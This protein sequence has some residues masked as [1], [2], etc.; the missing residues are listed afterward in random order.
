[1][2]QK[3]VILILAAVAVVIFA[4]IDFLFILVINN[5]IAYDKREKKRNNG[6]CYI[7]IQH[8]SSPMKK[9]VEDF[10]EIYDFLTSS[11]DKYY[12]IYA[13][14]VKME[15][16]EFFDYGGSGLVETKNGQSAKK[17]DAKTLQVSQNVLED[18]HIETEEGRSLAGEDFNYFPE[19]KIPV[20]M[21]SAYRDIYQIGDT[22]WAKYLFDIYEFEIVGIIQEGAE[23]YLGNGT[24]RLDEYIIMPSFYI[25]GHTEVT[26]GI[27]IH[28]ANKTSGILKVPAEE[29]ER[30]EN[31]YR[32]M[33]E[34]NRAGEYS[35][36]ISPASV[37]YKS[38]M[39]VDIYLLRN[40]AVLMLMALVMGEIVVLK[41]VKKK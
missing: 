36:T 12:E 27:K 3:K 37:F 25:S 14:P 10:Q 32:P 15:K 35:W 8:E 9:E 28:Y 21:G 16:G 13:Q 20:L 40:I 1:M 7:S 26:D 4:V 17:T 11:G 6:F 24:Y 31:Y 22:F 39:G 41:Q 5:L 34:N 23:A 33:L 2:K 29:Q 30:F 38:F 19:K 18:Y